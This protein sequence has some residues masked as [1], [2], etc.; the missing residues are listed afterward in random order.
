MNCLFWNVR[1][2]GKG[3]KS[4]SIKRLITEKK[5]SFM[6]L[7]ETKHRK[8]IRSRLKRMWG[9]DEFDFCK[10]Y[11]SDTHSGGVIAAWDIGT[12]NV[13]N[14]LS[15]DRWILLEGCVNNHQMKCCVGV[16]YGPNDRIARYAVFEEIKNVV[17]AIHKPI[18]LLGDFNVIL[19][20]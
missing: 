6:G 5:V 15:G 19:H 20:H 10:F 3:E 11:A 12:F 4:K 16:I 9:N 8:S 2:L 14:K 13:S 17:I 7:V 18:L 1:C